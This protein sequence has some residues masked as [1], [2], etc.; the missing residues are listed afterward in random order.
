MRCDS[1]LTLAQDSTLWK[2]RIKI[3]A[4]SV[5]F[6]F[7]FVHST[8]HMG[9]ILAGGRVLYEAGTLDGILSIATPNLIYGGI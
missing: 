8:G 4:S 3:D 6:S 1:I 2:K 7:G 5:R 9:N